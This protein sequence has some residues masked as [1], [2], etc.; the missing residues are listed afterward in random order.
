ML[1]LFALLF[2]QTRRSTLPSR[3]TPQ[4][5]RFN[6]TAKHQI[7]DRARYA[8]MISR[9]HHASQKRKLS[10]HRV[11][12]DLTPELRLVVRLRDPLLF[13]YVY[14]DYRRRGHRTRCCLYYSISSISHQQ[15]LYFPKPTYLIKPLAHLSRFHPDNR[16]RVI[17]V[18][19]HE[20]PPYDTLYPSP[21]RHTY[22]G[23]YAE[24]HG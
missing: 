5:T 14:V 3:A 22:L 20:S 6:S 4:S 18:P 12:R 17:P 9:S 10:T 13:R 2:C 16:W 7:D 21:N 15:M 23:W 1:G 8:V 11:K 24:L 19:F